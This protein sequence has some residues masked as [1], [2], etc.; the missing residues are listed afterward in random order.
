VPWRDTAGRFSWLKLLVFLGLFLPAAWLALRGLGGDLG[1]RPVTELLRRC[2]DWTVRLLLLT[3][4]VSPARA[5]WDWPR[6]VQL[7]R[8]LGV[9]TGCYALTHFSLYI[10]Q[11]NFHLLFVASEIV[12]RFYLTIGFTALCGLTTLLVT[13]TD[14]WQRRLRGGWKKLHRLIFP[15]ALLALTHYFIQSKINVTDAVFAAGVFVWLGSWRLL[16]RRMQARPLLFLALAVGAALATAGIETLWYLLA[17]GVPALRVLEAN[18]QIL[19]WPRPAVWVAIVFAAVALVGTVR[20]WK[21]RVRP[22]PIA[23]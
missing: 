2:G 19:P 21:R 11:Q 1:G 3:L 7:R 22:A 8:M 15:I 4:A 20:R 17:T 14:G 16:P 10:V 18:A 12:R 9:A 23:A 6:V 5:V 13:S